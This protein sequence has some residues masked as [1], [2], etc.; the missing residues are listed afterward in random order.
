[1]R[2]CSSCFSDTELKAIIEADSIIGD[3]DFCGKK[4]SF[5]YEIGSDARLSELFDEILDVYVPKTSLDPTIYNGPAKPLSETL[6]DDWNIF[7]LDS[8]QIY[9]LLCAICSERFQLTP[10]LFNDP[11]VIIQ[12]YDPLYLD[13]NSILRNSNWD[14]FLSS[15]KYCIR[16]H[17]NEVN[18]NILKKFLSCIEKTYQPNEIF[19]R[20]RVC[21]S[22]KGF[23]ITEMGA[24]PIDKAQAGRANAEGIQLLYLA[25]Q[26]ETTFYE[27]RASM[28]DYVTVGR[29]ELLRASKIV[30]LAAIKSI[31]PFVGDRYGFDYTQYAVNYQH[32]RMIALE[33][34][35]PMRRQDSPL[36]YIPTQYIS[37]FIKSQSYDGIE[38]I[39][40]MHKEGMNV[41][42]FDASALRCIGVETH[43][44]N[45][46][47]YSHAPY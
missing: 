12:S 34:S 32:L 33:I 30:N 26:E 1:M 9:N 29:F 10:E 16:F 31:S 2:C 7:S 36:D 27:T 24:P 13:E 46:I 25:N 19:F 17:N 35:R 43:R 23:P 40:T 41:A 4:S 20:A 21:S 42:F 38:Y 45:T 28:F 6:H 39:S 18:T 5:V 14:K 44:V 15:I 22:N 47:T 37:D 3:C 8:L 11:V